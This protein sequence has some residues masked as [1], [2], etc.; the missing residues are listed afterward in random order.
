MFKNKRWAFVLT[1][2]LLLSV[3]LAAC[4]AGETIV[5]VTRVITETVEVE[6]QTVEVT[7]VV[8]ETE[9]VVVTVEVPTEVDVPEPEP[10]VVDRN[11]GWLDTIVIV[12][13]PDSNSAVARLE[14]GDLDVYADDIAGEA[15]VQAIASDA[16]QTRTQYGLFDEIF[17][18]IGTCQ[19]ENVLNPFSNQTIRQALNYA[20]DRNYIAQ[21][22]YN[23]LAVPKYVS[24][25][26]AGAD[27]ARFAAEIRQLE[28]EFAY[29]FDRAEETIAAEMENLGATLEG[30]VWTYNGAPVNLIFLIRNE[31][32]RL[33]IGGYVA[34]Q[35][36][37]MG[38]QV[39]RVERTSGELAP[40]WIEGDPTLCE[41]NLY[42]GAWSQTAV[43]R[44]STFSFEQ[45]YT[46]RVLPWP[47]SAILDPPAELDEAAAAIYASDFGSLEERAELFR[48]AL[49]LT[50]EYMPRIWTTSRT[51]VVPFT[52]EVSVSTDLAGGISGSQLWSRTIRFADRV[53]GSMTIGLPSVFTQPWNPMGGSN[54]V[55]DAMVMRGISDAGVFS[56]PNTGLAV[57]GRIER[58][59]VV[60]TEGYPIASSSDWM[61]LSFEPE[62]TVPDDA[63]A[64]WDAEN[65]VFLTAA[66][67]YTETQTALI[68]STVYY[69]ADMYETVTWHDGSPISAADFIIQI[70]TSFDL[71][72]PASPY[73][74]E[75]WVPGRNQFL[76]NFKGVRIASTDPLVIETWGD[77]GSLDAENAI[78]TWYP[79]SLLARR[80]SDAAWHNWALVLRGEENGSFAMSSA[81]ATANE[82]EQTNLISGPS[83]ATL[84][85]E[86]T[87]AQEEGFIPYAATLGEYISEDD[88]DARYANLAE[89]ARRYGHYY[90][91]TGPYY[92]SGVFPVE[93]QAVLTHYAAH[94]DP[95]D[96]YAAF[97]APASPIVEIDGPARV[98]IGEEAAF[99]VFVDLGDTPYPAE[100]IDSI[101]YLVFDATGELVAEGTAEAV[102][103]GVWEVVLGSDVTSEMAEGSNR[104]DIVAVSRLVAIPTLASYEFVTAP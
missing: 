69:P 58:A 68:K 40:I 86:L 16:I 38:F 102:E 36:E 76:A 21:E 32:T 19:D 60:A 62:I 9:E 14:A 87:V 33:L 11:G 3:F 84:A 29:D 15:A 103:D 20:I 34:N 101:N 96:R 12:Q 44:E 89:F 18:N 78:S 64:G 42:T 66:D 35:L 31:D 7:R 70:I 6:G 23:G 93:G 65:Q 99:D 24:I 83:L 80:F 90:I 63:W 75:A 22:L 81:K 43:D 104:L 55:F 5:E 57:Q 2:L 37:D 94:P 56:D 26:E 48:T 53:G 82:V 27:R 72:D 73:Y 98:S 45:Y 51:T 85:E 30:G 10:E 8:T 1:A 97:G 92:L 79:S 50:L 52:N 41:W 13:E 54:W 100:D 25:A 88:A 95:A 67:V 39:E 59:E 91:S 4:Q 61:T 47:N 28:A 49:P 71:S 77:A 46:P 17:F 74:D